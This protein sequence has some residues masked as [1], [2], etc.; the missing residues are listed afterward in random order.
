MKKYSK[1]D[2]KLLALWGG[3][4]AKEGIMPIFEKECPKDDPAT[5]G[6]WGIALS[7][8]ALAFLKM[9]EIREASLA[10]HAAARA[11]LKATVRQARKVK[12]NSPACFA[13]YARQGKQLQPR[14]VP[15]HAFGAAYY[16]LKAIA[17]ADPGKNAE[18][19]VAKEFKWISK[20]AD[21]RLPKKLRK[22]ILDRIIIE[23]PAKT[24]FLLKYKKTRIFD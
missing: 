10:A 8:F 18:I 12:T 15:Q 19:K 11:T 1:E 24:K 2:Q 20:I 23:K 3:G 16:A 22:E 14:I 21:R 13:G 4:F 9:V 7:G 5:E 17:A 6:D